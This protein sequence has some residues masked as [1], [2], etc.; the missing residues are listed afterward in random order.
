M[1]QIKIDNLNRSIEAK[2]GKALLD[3]FLDEGI[4]IQHACGGFCA[5][6]TCQ[7]EVLAGAD[8][9]LEPAQEEEINRLE[10]TA[11][12]SSDTRRLSCQARIKGDLTVRIV[13]LE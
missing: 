13:N 5:C 2:A 7:V 11:G 4:Q 1:P 10:E 6:T 12:V 3:V 9:G 8:T